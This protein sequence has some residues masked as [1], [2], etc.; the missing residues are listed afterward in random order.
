MRSAWETGREAGL[1]SDAVDRV[2]RIDRG[3]YEV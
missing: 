1:W 3:I 2:Y